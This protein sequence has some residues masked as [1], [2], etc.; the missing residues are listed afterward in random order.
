MPFQGIRLSLLLLGTTAAA[1][2]A[3]DVPIPE[4]PTYNR[5]VRPILADACFR[6]HGFDKNTRKGD[7]RLDTREGALV[8]ND[9]VRAIV[10]G[11]PMASALLQRLVTDDADDVMPPPEEARQLSPR[12]KEILRRWVAGGG[13]YE[14]HWAYIPPS[15]PAIPQ[16]DPPEGNPVDRFVRS[17]LQSLKLTPAPEADRVTLARRVSY[18][19]TG[20]PPSAAEVTAFA[21]DAAPDA[22]ERMVDRLMASPAFGERMAVW[23][24]DQVRYADTIGYHSDNPMPVS[25]FRDYVIR[26]FNEN[27][28]FDQFTVEQIAGDLLPERTTENLVASA[29]NRLILSTEEGGAQAKQY[30]AKYLVD[31]VKSIGTTWLGQTFMCAECHDHKYDPVT[32]RDFYALGAFFA[33]IEEVAVGGRGPGVPVP[34]TA[35][36]TALAALRGKI[37]DLE[38]KLAGPHPELETE[39]QQWEQSLREAAGREAAW[40]TLPFD[41]RKAMEGTVLEPA[42]DGAILAKGA[43]ADGSYLLSAPFAGKVAGF[44]IE[45]L[46]HDSLPARGPGRAGNGNFVITEVVAR[47]K[48]A[49]GAEEEMP[50]SAA[51][52]SHEQMSHGE[53]TPWKGWPAAATVD[54]DEK[55]REWGWAILPE[56][57]KRHVLTLSCRTAATLAPGDR[58][59]I[60]LHQHHASGSHSLGHFRIAATAQPDPAAH[61]TV[62]AQPDLLAALAVAPEARNEAQR[63]LIESRFRESAK[64]LDPLRSQLAEA[65]KELAATEG[66]QPRCLVTTA[67]PNRRTVRILPRGDWQNESGD[68][69]L[70]ATPA[71]LP[72]PLSSSPEKPLNRL[73]LARWLVS[74]GQPL[75]ARVA[76]NRLW[77]LLFGGGLVKTLDDLG[78]QS[79]IPVQ[80]PLL[81]WLACEFEGSGWNVKQIVRLMVTSRTYRQS[82]V[83]QPAELARDPLNRDLARSGRW[84]L[85]A[86]FVRDNALAISG[87]L[88]RRVGGPS[89]KPWQPAGY[90]ENLNFPQRE[91][92]NSSGE[93]QWRR[94]LYTWWQRSYVQP[95]LLAFDA[96]TREE[97]SAD[98]TRSNIPQ[99]ALVLLNDLTYVE[100][101]R[102]FASRIVKEG[103]SEDQPRLAWGWL[104]ATG[105]QPSEKE[106]AT[107][108]ALLAKHRTAFQQDEKAAREA[109][110][111]GQFRVPDDIPVA[112]AAAWQSVARVLLNLH[113][114]ITRP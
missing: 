59:S 19:L 89:V 93:G 15:R 38:G 10:P 104:Q 4:K 64:G 70:P 53:N 47:V 87:L 113:E 75:T 9:G 12:E 11:D 63:Q 5:D 33:D 65:R 57:G 69:V 82:S 24:L 105:R 84:R 36:E 54:R 14:D 66:A 94:G 101:A 86:E 97:C 68:V 3:A 76:V 58:I 21:A 85:D 17:R 112:D 1:A 92:D 62:S 48:R 95:S 60:E 50:L 91:W 43:Q 45:A 88:V 108:A 107:L 41:E 61:A 102:A 31:R 90:W 77:K 37:G 52:A 18:D 2:A 46:P 110:G 71:F 16:T 73:D 74:P 49:S 44:R 20:L 100:A 55:G 114:T 96:P 106:S 7:R 103:G 98:R 25:P 29:Y 30:E 22:F 27:K 72:S 109:L 40:Q 78:T 23:W 83:G 13:E 111:G 39:R 80:Q 28:P 67:M 32:T 35:G 79:E 99:Q 51:H 26:A 8:E 56:A 6:C 81:D 34:D 42:A